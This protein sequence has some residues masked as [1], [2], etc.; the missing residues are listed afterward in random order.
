MGEAHMIFK[1]LLCEVS[2]V[3]VA[4]WTYELLVTTCEGEYWC[5]GAAICEPAPHFDK[6]FGRTKINMTC[7]LG[8]LWSLGLLIS[9]GRKCLQE[10]QD[11]EGDLSVLG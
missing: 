2:N 11:E 5:I 1:L 4:N 3:A 10:S 8:A 7:N 6:M 9:S